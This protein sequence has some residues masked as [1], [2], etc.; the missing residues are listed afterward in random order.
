MVLPQFFR[1]IYQIWRKP[2]REHLF[3]QRLKRTYRALSFF[4]FIAVILLLIGFNFYA[5]G[6]T[7]PLKL[8]ISSF[9]SPVIYGL[10]RLN[11]TL[12]NTI[13]HSFNQFR[14]ALSDAGQLETLKRDRA[15]LTAEL[16]DLKNTH[17]QLERFL[18]MS[19]MEALPSI[20]TNAF[21]HMSDGIHHSFFINANGLALTAHMPVTTPDG[22][23]GKI[24][25][26]SGKIARVTTLVDPHFKL[27]VII[28]RLNIQA[29]A[30]GDGARGMKILYSEKPE[31]LHV[32]DPLITSGQ[33]G[34]FPKGLY[35][36]FV[37]QVTPDVKVQVAVNPMDVQFVHVLEPS[38]SALLTPT[39][40]PHLQETKKP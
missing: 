24:T 4:P 7:D 2:S 11:T 18:K 20:T 6:F 12:F 14:Q 22:I 27:P 40:A 15:R 9:C 28:T 31:T 38:A 33:G 13:P 32:G 25:A 39:S 29:I 5:P 3:S 16:Q 26:V 21:G 17:A 19:S 35:V 30:V 1:L 34:I 8:H 23:V 37:S 10:D 36:G